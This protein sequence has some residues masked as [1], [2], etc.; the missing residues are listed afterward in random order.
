MLNQFAKILLFLT[1]GITSCRNSDFSLYFN[2]DEYVKGTP[3]GTIQFSENQFIDKTEITNFSWLEYRSWLKDKYGSDSQEYIHSK[4]ATD[5]WI[6]ID[7]LYEDYA[8]FY[9]T[10]PAYQDYPLVGVSFKQAKEFSIWRSD[11]VFELILIKNGVLN[12][13]SLKTNKIVF[14]RSQFFEDENFSKYHHIPYPNYSLVP[15]EMWES[16]LEF[17]DSLKTSNIKSCKQRSLLWKFRTEDVYCTEII[18]DDEFVINSIELKYSFEKVE[19][20]TMVDCYTCNKD[21]VYQLLGNVAELT[22]DSTKVF[23][24]SF[25]DSL[26]TIQNQHLQIS[27]APNCFTGFRNLCT[28]QFW[29]QN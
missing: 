22:S 28:W 27:S 13:D 25:I 21:L 17:S 3:P 26:T 2:E 12:W 23:G 16:I 5:C 15:P 18:K 14:T 6:K 19:P 1:F 11:R 8:D 29:N 20:T 9:L 4:P 24:G 10:H 7:S